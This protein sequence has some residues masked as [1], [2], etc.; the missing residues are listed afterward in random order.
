MD[1]VRRRTTLRGL[2]LMV[3][4]AAVWFSFLARRDR[5]RTVA[6][7]LLAEA[8]RPEFVSYAHPTAPGEKT[9]EGDHLNALASAAASDARRFDWL[10][11]ACAI[12]PF[13]VPGVAVGRTIRR[14]AA[15]AE[16]IP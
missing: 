15:A 8:Q 4:C 2:M 3:A 1:L 16:I 12:I 6:L 14:R 10:M 9:P 7:D 5:L 11:A 13:I